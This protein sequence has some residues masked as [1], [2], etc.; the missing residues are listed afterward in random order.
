MRLR[1]ARNQLERWLLGAASV[2]PLLLLGLMIWQLA[3]PQRGGFLA[4]TEIGAPYLFLPLLALLPFAL[5]GRARLL[6]LLLLGCGLIYSARFLP[7]MVSLP[8]GE[9]PGTVQLTAMTWNTYIGNERVDKL[10][11][12]L[13]DAAVQ[14]I[15]LQELSRA[16]A[17]VIER[18]SVLTERYPYRV[19]WP[20]E[21]A[22]GMGL[23]SAYPILEQGRLDSPPT[24]W[25]RLD[26]G[27]GQT[28]MVVNSH[29]QPGHISMLRPSW[30]IPRGF[31]PTLRD[32][33]IRNVRALI[34]P[35]LQRGEALLVMGDYNVTDREPAY[36]EL[37]AGLRDAHLDVGIGSGHSWR[38][39]PL[40]R[41]NWALV[42]IDYLLTSPQIIPLSVVTDCTPRGSDHCSVRGTFELR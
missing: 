20:Q 27:N 24:I 4:I 7:G 32:A 3:A 28:L 21:N 10:P 35:M 41:Y 29:P 30:P 25:A 12:T 40:M 18:D 11:E 6:R 14:I 34:E 5:S 17:R 23:L 2:Y 38:P 37:A 13:R 15:G 16:Q 22:R 31:D 9:T 36:R 39:A 19:L 42:R 33:L 26:L 8:P 1:S